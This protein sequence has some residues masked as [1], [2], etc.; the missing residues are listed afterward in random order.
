MTFLYGLKSLPLEIMNNSCEER[1]A[2]S[3]TGFY[4]MNILSESTEL[5]NIEKQETVVKN[6]QINCCANLQCWKANNNSNNTVTEE[7][8]TLCIDKLKGIHAVFKIIAVL[9]GII[10]TL[11]PFIPQIVAGIKTTKTATEFS[12]VTTTTITEISTT[13]TTSTAE[14][15]IAATMSKYSTET[16]QTTKLRQIERVPVILYLFIFNFFSEWSFY[17]RHNESC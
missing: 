9:I 7:N 8:R 1:S 5:L 11:S 16:T 15:S 13:T 17:S 3:S 4:Q 2:E 14:L 12:E 6:V 10:I